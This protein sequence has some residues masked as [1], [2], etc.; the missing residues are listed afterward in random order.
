V[1]KAG[2]PPEARDAIERAAAEIFVGRER[3][4]AQLDAAVAEVLAGR[5]RLCLIAGEPGIGKTRLAEHVA[6]RAG[7]RGATVVW[8]RC[9]EGE[10]APAFWPW[11]QV[12]RAL[13]RKCE[14]KT[15]AR[16]LGLGGPYVA[17]LVPEVRELLPDLASAPPL[18]SEQAR[19][20]LYDACCTFL[21]S[22]AADAPLVLVVDDLHWADK[23]SLLLLQFLVREIAD[24]RLLVLGTYRDVEVSRDHPLADVLP[25]L[26][27]ERTVDRVLL[28]GLP[29]AEIHSLLVA[30]NGGEVP[31]A[32]TRTLSRETAGN[33]FFIRE[34]LR[35]LLDEG[36][37]YR[38]GDRW[39]GRV[40]P[41]ELQLPE[42]V[43]EVVGRRV[44][45]LG[46]ACTKVLT[47]AAV[48]GQEFGLDVLER[49]SDL[50]ADRT[51]EVLEEAI[52]AR[53]IEAVPRSIARYRFSHALIRETLYGA[54]RTLERAR[55]CIAG[56][57]R[58]WRRSTPGT[59][60]R[61]SRSSPTTSCKVSRAARSTRPSPTRPLPVTARASSS[62]T[63]RRPS[64][65]SGR[66][67][68]SSSRNRPTR[69][70]AASFY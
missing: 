55:A 25:Q 20:R 24:A 8:G 37:A 67:K 32:F 4:R 28:R 47:L 7:E 34:I 45:R 35:N 51:A 60:S 61:T 65:T 44:A 3:E 39:V 40:Q 62:P 11:V 54:I 33:P 15:M 64:S 27:R 10:G 2:I 16:W 56:W 46:D 50:A 21:T 42:S 49:V 30:L 68:R 13:L 23:S 69:D 43:R 26:R 38:D 36:L 14:A 48:I 58:C 41:G 31:E 12:I 18:D 29:E 22:V 9:W 6:G 57:P 53:V 17:Q 52:S 63:P 66:C 59:P 1:S 5:G 19:F 70:D